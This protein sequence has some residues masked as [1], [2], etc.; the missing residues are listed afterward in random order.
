MDWTVVANRNGKE[1]QT[2]PSQRRRNGVGVQVD[3]YRHVRQQVG[4]RCRGSVAVA[5]CGPGTPRTRRAGDTA[6]KRR[7][8]GR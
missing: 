6:T 8:Q 7:T 2:V 1:A 5:R 3:L 4:P